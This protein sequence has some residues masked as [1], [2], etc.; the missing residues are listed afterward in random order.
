[1]TLEESYN[2]SFPNATTCLVTLALPGEHM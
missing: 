2:Q 1:M